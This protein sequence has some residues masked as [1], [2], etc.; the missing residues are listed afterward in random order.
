MI[1]F[2][3]VPETVQRLATGCF[4][5]RFG[6]DDLMEMTPPNALAVADNFNIT[7]KEYIEAIR[8]LGNFHT[9]HAD[10]LLRYVGHRS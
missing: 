9:T 10:A 1:E 8:W 6:P 4:L 2:N 3:K 5:Q 7:P